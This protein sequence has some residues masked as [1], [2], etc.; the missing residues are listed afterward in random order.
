MGFNM[1]HIV[2]WQNDKMNIIYPTKLNWLDNEYTLWGRIFRR[3][4]HFY[5]QCLINEREILNFDSLHPNQSDI[6]DASNDHS[7]LSN[8][9]KGI[10][11]VIYFKNELWRE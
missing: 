9:C 6:L 5:G 1:L 11:R 8:V 4:G 10:E 2:E 7:A 3:P